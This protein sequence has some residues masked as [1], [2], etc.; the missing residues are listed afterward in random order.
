MARVKIRQIRQAE[1]SKVL[2]VKELFAVGYADLGSSIYYALG[3]TALF[4]LG[5]TPLAML[6][7]GIVFICTALTYA[8]LSS[9]FHEA[10]GSSS[11]AR[12]AFNDVASFIA[13]WGLLLDYI[14][15]IA[16]SAFAVAPYFSS[17][18][19]EM[20]SS[21]V[22][23]VC[24]VILIGILYIINY[25]GIRKSARFNW[26]IVIVALGSQLLIIALG[27][28]SFLHLDL[29]FERM[30]IGGADALYSPSWKNF[31][32]GTVMAMVAYTGIESIAQLGSET[33]KPEKNLPRAIFT[34]MGILVFVY[35]GISIVS[36][37]VILPKAL[38]TTYINDPIAGVVAHLPGGAILGP[39]LGVIT[40]AILLAAANTGL[41]GSSR[42][43]FNMGQYYML[44][45][46]LYKL[47]PKHKTPYISLALFAIVASAIVI[48]SRGRMDFLADLY[49]FGAMIAFCS[50][51]LSLIALRI[52]QPNKKRPFRVPLNI[53]FGKVY[54][55]IS[56][57]IGVLATASVW[58][59]IVITKPEGRYL[60]LAWIV[61]GLAMFFAYRR[62]K[63]LD[64]SHLEI[65][66]VD[67]PNYTKFDVQNI[68]VLTCGPSNTPILQMACEL[69]KIHGAKV[70]ALHIAIIAE[71]VPFD[72]T[73][74]IKLYPKDSA[75]ESAVLIGEEMNTPIETKTVYA[76]TVV[77]GALQEVKNRAYDLVVIGGGRKKI[78]DALEKSLRAHGCSILTYTP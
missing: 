15:T 37:S 13:G 72:D 73:L 4:A 53:R 25:L 74:P 54:L 29:L 9:M 70:T 69:S 39:F 14:V 3:V 67:L 18:V 22:Q 76:R 6:M 38:G 59:M 7:A 78:A 42:L 56:A 65:E 2:G 52:R 62:Q 19:P 77:R 48:A 57:L 20:R 12:H 24:T 46:F 33:E 36:M 58:V 34:I 55:P 44:P 11:F 66:Q 17:F 23:V 16:I 30:R 60:G 47:H 43:A 21:E 68:L 45:R 41:I 49:N 51:H 5:A 32:T 31:W 27:Y 75:L 61:A 28:K 35:V 71:T 40:G 63:N 1:M 64:T 10:G 26:A 8:E 50:A